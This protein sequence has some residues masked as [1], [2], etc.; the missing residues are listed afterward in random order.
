MPADADRESYR[1]PATATAEQVYAV[2]RAALDVL[3]PAVDSAWVDE[4]ATVSAERADALEQL[5]KV[6]AAQ[7]QEGR[8]PR[9]DEPHLGVDLDPAVPGQ[10]DL[11]A[12]L[13]PSSA[14]EAYSADEDPLIVVA[15][16]GRDVRLSLTAVELD[17]LRTLLAGIEVPALTKG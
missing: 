2:L 8:L 10:L 14:A 6:A 15:E 16:G 7:V 17:R 5:R 13:G 1:L 3:A 4:P 11:V 9:S 12:L